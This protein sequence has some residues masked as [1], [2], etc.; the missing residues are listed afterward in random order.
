MP[1]NKSTC[2]PPR[3]QF[4]KQLQATK[5][6]LDNLRGDGPIDTRFRQLVTPPDPR[7]KGG[8][9]ADRRI[10]VAIID[11]GVD[12]MRDDVREAIEKGISFVSADPEEP[13]RVLPWWMVADPHGTQMASL[14]KQVNPY[15]RL[16]IARV[17]VGRGRIKPQDAADAICWALEQ[18]VDVI[19]ISWV[20]KSPDTK[21]H[22]AVAKAVM[23]KG[24]RA[25]GAQRPT[26]VFCSTS[27]EGA[28]PVDAYPAGWEG[29]VCVAATDQYGHRRPPSADNVS[30][31]AP[32][33][34]VLA[35]GPSYI[36]EFTRGTVTGSSVATALGAGLASLALLML[37]T[38][39]AAN[40]NDMAS[41]YTKEGILGVF[42]K[43]MINDASAIQLATLFPNRPDELEELWQVKNFPPVKT[44]R[45][46]KGSEST[47]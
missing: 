31:L 44:S 1:T 39:N 17:G 19:S 6:Y 5:D 21:L 12:R 24:W 33:E 22:D 30:I 15:A 43:M 38:F 2:A 47:A 29:V 42:R 8:L 35:D 45:D 3:L 46:E 23:R 32:G 25:R 37:R 20:T 4:L 34:N 27:D 28:N 13:D 7:T 14:V 36:P 16:Y 41:F 11:N 10:K 9:T 26:L 18:N 40:D